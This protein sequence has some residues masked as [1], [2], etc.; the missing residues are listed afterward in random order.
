M[1]INTRKRG[2]LQNIT[3]YLP[4]QYLGSEI[5][6]A[7]IKTYNQLQ[8]A[9]DH[10]VVEPSPHGFIELGR[11]SMMQ[12]RELILKPNFPDHPGIYFDATY[13]SIILSTFSWHHIEKYKQERSG[14][15]LQKLREKSLKEFAENLR[16][17]LK[18]C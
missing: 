9:C 12:E 6:H 14:E 15:I 1:F 13:T 3:I 8:L 10:F 18:V 4:Y 17:A 11:A 2:V 16:S 5:F 7:M